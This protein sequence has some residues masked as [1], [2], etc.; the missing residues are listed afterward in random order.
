[1]PKYRVTQPSFI[2]GRMF[3]AGDVINFDGVPGFNLDPVDD[4]AKK[5]KAAASKAASRNV[6]KSDLAQSM[7]D[8]VANEGKEEA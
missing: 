6:N 8:N 4:A 7:A 5:A 1:M 2:H 3:K